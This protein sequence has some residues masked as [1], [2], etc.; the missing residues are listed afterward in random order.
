M[1]TTGDIQFKKKKK[2]TGVIKYHPI[3]INNLLK[4][5]KSTILW[6]KK[7]K[8]YIYFLSIHIQILYFTSIVFR[9][10]L[11]SVGRALLPTCTSPSTDKCSNLTSIVGISIPTLKQ[12]LSQIK[13][14]KIYK[15]E[16]QTIFSTDFEPFF[17][18]GKIEKG[19][20]PI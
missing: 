1:L 2:T 15:N 6:K 8:I 3:V 19:N 4:T 11:S 5:I 14:L 9:V 7:N 20:R 17:L 12:T 16:V 18:F 13:I 10:A